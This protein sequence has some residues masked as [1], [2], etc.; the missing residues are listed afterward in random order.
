MKKGLTEIVLILDRSGSMEE[1]KKDAEGGL[2]NFV[3]K[4]KETPGEC[5]LTFYRFDTII[6]CVFAEKKL[7]DITKDDLILDPRGGTALLDA[8]G[9]AITEV[10]QR[11]SE[12]P[13]DQRP[14]HVIVVIVTDGEENSSKKFS[15]QDIN[16]MITK[17]RDIY[18]WEFI[19]IGANQDAIATA[20]KMGIAPGNALTYSQ[21]RVG[22]QSSYAAVAMATSR[23]RTGSTAAFTQAERDSSF[24]N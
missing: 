22:T 11:L 16:E 14:E 15:V 9:K 7:A 21:N 23:V 13:E 5:V 2:K 6:E 20:V 17:Q 3:D 10:G 19:Y 24:K 4:Q 18:K 8:E 12:K 1:T